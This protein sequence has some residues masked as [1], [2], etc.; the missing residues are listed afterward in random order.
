MDGKEDKSAGTL[1][2]IAGLIAAVKLARTI[3]R[4]SMEREVRVSA[5]R[6]RIRSGSRRWLSKNCCKTMTCSN[7]AP[8]VASY[9][10]AEEYDSY[11]H[12]ITWSG[13]P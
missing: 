2:V 8:Q 3:R 13:E 6:S 1:A 9:L 10:R 5:A 7:S 12:A 11:Q 4:N